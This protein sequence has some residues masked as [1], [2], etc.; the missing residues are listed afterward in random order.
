MYGGKQ[1]WLKRERRN[2]LFLT[3]FVFGRFHFKAYVS[4]DS[5]LRYPV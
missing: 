1:S 3:K 4:L 5:I 2:F